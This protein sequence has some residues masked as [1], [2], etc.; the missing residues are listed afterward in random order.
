M[1]RALLPV[2]MACLASPLWA[3]DVALLLAVD[4]SGSIDPHEFALETTGLANALESPDIMDALVKGQVSLE[5]VHWSGVNKQRV[6]VPWAQM[7]TPEDVA[8]FADATRALKRPREYSDTAI[9][10]AILFSLQQFNTVTDCDQQVI[11]VS[12]DGRENASRSLPQ[13]RAQAEALGVTVNAIA[14]EINETSHDLSLYFQD[15]VITGNGFVETAQGTED[16]PRAIRA[17]LL[18]ELTKPVS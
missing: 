12:G 18:R 8:I 15:R 9:G 13:A 6:T 14:I 5:L 11:D 2:A 3:C 10:E 1:L 17:K 4:E 16:Y 7:K